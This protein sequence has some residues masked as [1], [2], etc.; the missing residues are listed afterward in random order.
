[1][2]ANNITLEEIA[3]KNAISISAAM[4]IGFPLE[5]LADTAPCGT[6][7]AVSKGSGMVAG[8][9]VGM[10]INRYWAQDALLNGFDY[11]GKFASY[12]P[13]FWPQPGSL[14]PNGYTV[15]MA[16]STT[17]TMTWYNVVVP[18]AGTYTA[19]FRY[20][21]DFGLFPSITDRPEVILVNGIVVDRNM[22]F[23]RT[24]SFG[25]FCH[26]AI[27]VHLDSGR[28]E[29]QMANFTDHGLS[30]VDDMTVGPTNGA[31]TP[32]NGLPAPASP[33]ECNNLP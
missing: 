23:I 18:I 9:S 15:D 2:C 10:S 3:M 21:F 26:S 5:T 30:R 7:I 32:V 24:G 19:K 22:H 14:A 29:I 8:V 4:L 1:M 28:N 31:I 11:F 27:N 13:V 33:T 16:Y 17:G 25:V 12:F 6:P 20:A